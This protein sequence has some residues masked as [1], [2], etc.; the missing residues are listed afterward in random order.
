MI[1]ITAGAVPERNKVNYNG[2]K[3]IYRASELH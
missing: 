3:L 2:K 1:T